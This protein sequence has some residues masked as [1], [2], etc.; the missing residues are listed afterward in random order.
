MSFPTI[1]T[2]IR[3]VVLVAALAALLFATAVRTPPARATTAEALV[4]WYPIELPNALGDYSAS[5]DPLRIRAAAGGTVQLGPALGRTAARFPAPC[6]AR[7]PATCP[8]AIL[9]AA[10]SPVHDPGTRPMRY[11]AVVALLPGQTDAGENI[12]QKGYSVGGSQWKLQV[13]GAAGQPSCV[14][15]GGKPNVIYRVTAPVS[16]VDGGW[17]AIECRRGIGVL[18][19]VVDTLPRAA[20]A[21]PASLNVASSQPVRLGGKGVGRNNDQFHGY[22]DAA[23]VYIG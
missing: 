1:R 21:V 23:W 19:I 9:E 10:A 17:H 4:A 5:A 3:L 16:I 22:L 13:D 15:A 20:V 18:S 2:A 8:R 12:L 7:T 11:G 14:L 6:A